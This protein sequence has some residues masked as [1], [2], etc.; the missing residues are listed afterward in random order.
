MFTTVYNVMITYR[1]PPMLKRGGCHPRS[2]DLQSQ[3]RRIKAGAPNAGTDSKGDPA[4]RPD[5]TGL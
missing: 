5:Q 1:L 2:A 3:I 4:H